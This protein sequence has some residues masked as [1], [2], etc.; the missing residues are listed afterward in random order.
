MGEE[1]FGPVKVMCSNRWK[2]QG[3]EA[4]VGELGI[5]EEGEYRGLQGQHLKCK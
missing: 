1:A 5:R 4:G 2:C 3:Q